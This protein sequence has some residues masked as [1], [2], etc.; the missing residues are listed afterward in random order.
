MRKNHW[1]AP[2]PCHHMFR[3]K[4]RGL[5]N[6]YFIVPTKSDTSNRE[7]CKLQ[8]PSCSGECQEYG[9]PAETNLIS[10]ICIGS[11]GASWSARKTRDASLFV[12]W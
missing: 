6:G 1:R 3:R 11:N 7:S 2:T 8:N 9:Y 4:N 12:L 5:I 10:A